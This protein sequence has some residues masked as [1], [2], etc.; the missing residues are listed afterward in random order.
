MLLKWIVLLLFSASLTPVHSNRNRHSS[1]PGVLSNRLAA[2][3]RSVKELSSLIKNL[4]AKGATVVLTNEK[5]SQPFF[6]VAAR[7]INVNGQSVQVFEFP[8]AAAAKAETKR[9]G[10]K[11]TTSV[12]WIAPPHFFHGG[13][14][15][16]L[17]VGDNE[18]ILKLLTTVLGPQ[19]AGQ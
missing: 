1:Q 7:I 16:V 2:K 10:V 11:G 3:G 9:I 18:S 4:R 5:V 17:Y 12:A 8:N 6:P 15:I 13:R 14:L 19:F